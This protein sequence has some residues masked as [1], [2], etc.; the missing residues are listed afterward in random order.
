MGSHGATFLTM[1]TSKPIT[2][3][4]ASFMDSPQAAALGASDGEVRT[5]VERFLSVCYD[6]MGSAPKTMDGQAMHGALGHLLPGRFQRGEDLA[7]KVP[8]VL[9]AYIE[10]LEATEVVIN[11]FELKRGFESTIDEFLQ[12]VRTGTNPHGH[13]HA[14]PKDP[15]QHGAAKLGRNDPCSCGSGRK[16]KKCHGKGA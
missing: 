15:F 10:H 3:A 9:R 6:D 11:A 7:D 13:G 5:I 4:M 12:T 14:P 16:Y 8:A 2:L 1:A